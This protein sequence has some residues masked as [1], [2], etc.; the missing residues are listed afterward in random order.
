MSWLSSPLICSPRSQGGNGVTEVGATLPRLHALHA[1]GT[2][3]RITARAVIDASDTWPTPGPLGGEAS[4][5]S[6]SAWRPPGFP[7]AY[8]ISRTPRCGPAMRAGTPPSSALAPP[9]SAPWPPSP[10]T[11]PAF[12]PYGP[13]ARHQ[14]LHIQ[15][16]CGGPAARAW[17]AGPGEAE[18]AVD[19]GYA[20]AVTGFC[21]AAVN[22]GGRTHTK[23]TVSGRRWRDSWRMCSPR[24]LG[25]TI[26]PREAS[27]ILPPARCNGACSC[28]RSRRLDTDRRTLARIP[29]NVTHREKWRV[30]LDMLDTLAGWGMRPPVVV[31][32]AAY[33]ANAHL[34][35]ALNDRHS[36]TCSPSGPMCAP[37]P[38]RRSLRLRPA[39]VSS[40]AAVSLPAGR[41]R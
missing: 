18:A 38:S 2:E 34:R 17:S 10:R 37:T 39:T 32:D 4:L 28:P 27:P 12:T 3:T 31:A 5:A 9:P 13:A 16:R 23:S 7:T 8:P 35:A 36:P 30:A 22:R 20:D 15:W 11:P 25:R 6:A 1:D 41:R 14:R 33:G 40:A 21:T 24:Y 19:D 26:G 29:D